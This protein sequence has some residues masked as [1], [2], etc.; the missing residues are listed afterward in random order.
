LEKI[1]ALEIEKLIQKLLRK[2]INL[3]V[4]KE[5]IFALAQKSAELDR[6]ARGVR[7]IIIEEVEN[8]VA[9]KMLNKQPKNITLK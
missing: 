3:T 7:K 2:K 4:T 1:V 5:K 9:Q 8:L 6:G